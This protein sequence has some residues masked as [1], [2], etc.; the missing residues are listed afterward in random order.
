MFE[1]GRPPGRVKS[2]RERERS[3]KV[4]RQ[5]VRDHPEAKSANGGHNKTKK[6][7]GDSSWHQQKWPKARDICICEMHFIGSILFKNMM[8]K[9][10]FTR[11][12]S[13]G[14]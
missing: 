10:G 4:W 9:I 2:G 5:T 7:R 13:Y 12:S 14:I 1:S 8:Y 3:E 11:I 6:P